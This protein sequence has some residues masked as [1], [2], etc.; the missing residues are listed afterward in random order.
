MI[1]GGDLEDRSEEESEARAHGIQN[2]L[3]GAHFRREQR[4]PWADHKQACYNDAKAIPTPEIRNQ[5]A[6]IRKRYGRDL[7]ETPPQVAPHGSKKETS[8]PDTAEKKSKKKD[9]QQIPVFYSS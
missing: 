5:I 8:S 6:H 3:E 4:E 1:V 9:R 7:A 2:D